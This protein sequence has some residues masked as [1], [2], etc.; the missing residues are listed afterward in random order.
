MG[1][2]T[3]GL[4]ALCFCICAAFQGCS[5]DLGQK[6]TLQSSNGSV[7]LSPPPAPAPAPAPP[8]TPVVATVAAVQ[9]FAD[10]AAGGRTVMISGSDFQ[11]GVIASVNGTPCSASTYISATQ[12][13]CVV[14]AAPTGSFS[15][16]SISVANPG[17]SAAVLN[18]AFFYVGSPKLWLKAD[19][20]VTQAGGLVS[21][22]ADQSGTA[23]NAAQAAAGLQPT[24]VAA[25]PEFNGMP[26]IKFSGA[27]QMALANLAVLNNVAGASS[28]MA[29]STAAPTAAQAIVSYEVNGSANGRF[30]MLINDT[31]AQIGNYA[32]AVSVHGRRLDADPC[33]QV[34]GGSTIAGTAFEAVA[35]VDYVNQSALI[36]LNRKVVSASSAFQTAGNSAATNSTNAVIGSK[37]GQYFLNGNVAELLLFSSAISG[38]QRQMLEN[39]LQ[40]RFNLPGPA[41]SIFTNQVPAA[42]A[43]NDGVAYELGVKFKSAQA[44]K[45][46]SVMYYKSASETGVHTGHIWK[47]DGTL[48]ATATFINEGLS[49]WQTATVSPPVVIQA[50]TT[51]VASV[52]INAFYVSTPNGLAAAVANGQLSTI[53]D[54]ANGVFAQTQAT[55]PAGT[56]SNTN[57]FVDVS[58]SP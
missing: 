36:S 2:I 23:N 4:S 13:S 29:V 16:V 20:G 3:F 46:T 39:Y 19:A 1:R 49:G 15:Q 25:A 34:S 9:P 32:G 42:L 57:Y 58:F 52:G 22:W 51:Y 7:P 48:L 14:P 35:S 24:Y 8:P 50:A 54:G 41:T 17:T 43:N 53:A 28:A 30:T 27:Q 47:A 12:L 37:D 38:S 10:V 45:I 44:G 40:K 11:K 21:A 55:F 18:N 31:C 33:Q 26:A 6:Q 56:F 5:E